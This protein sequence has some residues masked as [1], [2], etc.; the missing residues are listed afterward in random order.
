MKLDL[1]EIALNLGKKHK[2]II[3]EPAFGELSI[4]VSNNAPI[5]GEVVFSNIGSVIYVKGFIKTEIDILCSRCLDTYKQQ[6]NKQVEEVLPIAKANIDKSF[7]DENYLEDLDE[8]LFV[9][10]IFDLS[11]MLRQ[12]ILLEV[13][14]KP[15]CKEDCKGLCSSCGANLNY[16]SCSCSEKEVN[17]PFSELSDLL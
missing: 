3:D 17:N 11:E 4:E 6:V 7:D 14:Y 9:D 16:D 5:S 15:L 12:Y 8:P 1:T 10:N 13:P 2:Y